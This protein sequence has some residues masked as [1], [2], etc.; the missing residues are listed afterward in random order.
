MELSENLL[1]CGRVR[2]DAII[3]SVSIAHA[4]G[5]DKCILSE[6]LGGYLG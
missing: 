2:Y 1:E 6:C 3:N 4:I 5:L